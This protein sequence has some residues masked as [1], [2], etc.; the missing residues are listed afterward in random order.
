MCP[1]DLLIQFC[2]TNDFH[3]ERELK[4]ENEIGYRSFLCVSVVH[5]L[6]F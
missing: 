5:D 2:Y 6:E 1:L 4:Y 3:H